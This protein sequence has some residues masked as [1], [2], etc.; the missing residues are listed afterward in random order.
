M[1]NLNSYTGNVEV[2]DGLT[3]ANGQD[4]ALM[5]AHH[6]QVDENGKRLDQKLDE[7]GQNT[8]GGSYVLELTAESGTLTDEQYNAVVANAPNVIVKF[9]DGTAGD[10]YMHSISYY[11]EAGAY[12]FANTQ[13][14]EDIEGT[15]SNIVDLT[16]YM[17]AIQA[18]KSY[19]VMINSTRVPNRT[20]VD[21][22]VA[23]AGGGKAIID[24]DINNLPTNDINENVLYRDNDGNLHHYWGAELLQ[25]DPAPITLNYGG[26]V[27]LYDF[28][29]AL[30]A[31]TNKGT[32]VFWMDGYVA[33]A[34]VGMDMATETVYFLNAS[35][36]ELITVAVAEDNSSL[37][38]NR[39][40][41]GG[42]GGSGSIVK[43]EFSTLAE[44]AT[45]LYNNQDLAVIETRINGEYSITTTDGVERD[46]TIADIH[47]ASLGSI[48]I[49]S[50]REQ[51]IGASANSYFNFYNGNITTNAKVHLELADGTEHWIKDGTFND[52][53]NG[54]TV[55]AWFANT[56][57]TSSGSSGG[58]IIDVTELPTENIDTTALY[59][60]NGVLFHNVNGEFTITS[61][62]PV[63]LGEE[64]DP[65]VEQ[66]YSAV[67]N[68]IGMGGTIYL[69]DGNDVCAV[70]GMDVVTMTVFFMKTST[71]QLV[72]LGTNED[73]TALTRNYI[74][75]GSGGGGAS[76][77]KTIEATL[78][79]SEGY[80]NVT[81]SGTLS[82]TEAEVETIKSNAASLVILALLQ[83][84][85]I[86]L[87][88]SAVDIISGGANYVG[89]LVGFGTFGSA[90]MTC[91]LKTS[92]GYVLTS[93][94]E[95]VSDLFSFGL[96]K[97]ITKTTDG[98]IAISG[99]T[100]SIGCDS[101]SSWSKTL[102]AQTPIYVKPSF[103][104]GVIWVGK[105]A[106]GADTDA[107][108][109]DVV[110]YDGESK[111]TVKVVPM[112]GTME[113]TNTSESNLSTLSEIFAEGNKLTVY[114][115]VI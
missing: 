97:L 50:I 85:P 22:A 14:I 42:G 23:N 89:K 75:L 33:C 10:V 114:Y 67:E 61:P 106:Q 71:N 55:T 66:F 102:P 78:D 46:F 77:I 4:F 112:N 86:P 28:M 72:A 57:G 100:G 34:V 36:N 21:N 110:Y 18:D 45:Y 52:M 31:Y 69:I 27:T 113:L 99:T 81:G 105:Q 65:T 13:A 16:L 35:T 84:V 1:S 62:L 115:G 9:V 73:G 49:V 25:I 83:D 29:T 6:I 30:G 15:G 7:M 11:E 2:I 108:V 12:G 94:K 20:Y 95:Q 43:K 92:G 93:V 51:G 109:F 70:A 41:L 76:I 54:G 68:C 44:L 111:G 103:P 79:T 19:F 101:L 17:C 64:G 82:L 39:I 59:R 38:V 107:V 8:G 26:N 80:L 56:N 32:A 87:V 60:M 47:T 74:S 88:Y 104:S 48:F 58:G 98:N 37:A 40:S 24:A 3:P 63:V 5:Q 90:I 53:K 96:K 91:N